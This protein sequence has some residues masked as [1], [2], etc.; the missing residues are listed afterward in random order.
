MLLMQQ[1]ALSVSF[2]FHLKGTSSIVGS[3]DKNSSGYFVAGL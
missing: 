2:S 3:N 1:V